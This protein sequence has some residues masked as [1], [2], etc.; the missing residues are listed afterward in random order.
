[1]LALYALVAA[2]LTMSATVVDAQ[3]PKAQCLQID[4]SWKY[5]KGLSGFYV[6]QQPP[7]TAQNAAIFF[8]PRTDLV[9]PKNTPKDIFEANFG[10]FLQGNAALGGGRET[11][12]SF[13]KRNYGCPLYTHFHRQYLISMYCMDVVTAAA[14]NCGNQNLKPLCQST[15]NKYADST[16][17]SFRNGTQCPPA[18]D[19]AA[20]GI[21]ASAMNNRTT[22]TTSI[23]TFCNSAPFN[24]GS[25]N[26]LSG[27]VIEPQ[28]CGFVSI[29][30]MCDGKSCS[31]ASDMCTKL[32][33]PFPAGLSAA[34]PSTTA[35]GPIATG[36]ASTGDA[37]TASPAPVVPIVLGATLG[38][39]F[40][41]VAAVYLWRWRVDR[42]RRERYMAGFN[43]RDNGASQAGA[44]KPGSAWGPGEDA[45]PVPPMPGYASPPPMQQQQF[46][47][48]GGGEMDP[49]GKFGA[50]WMVDNPQQQQQQQFPGSPTT[51]Q[52]GAT[53]PMMQQ[54]QQQY[55]GYPTSPTA[56]VSTAPQLPPMGPTPTTKANK[57][58]SSLIVDR[59]VS[60]T[61]LLRASLALD[62]DAAALAVAGK[63]LPAVPP[64]PAGANGGGG[65]PPPVV[66][67]VQPVQHR[68]VRTYQPTMEDEMELVPGDLVSVSQSYDDG[69]GFGINLATG[70]VGVL[71]M[72]FVVR[73]E[74]DVDVRAVPIRQSMYGNADKLREVRDQEAARAAQA[75]QRA[76]A[77]QKQQQG[78]TSPQ[79]QTVDT[80]R[81]S[82]SGAMMTA[83]ETMF[84]GDDEDDDGSVAHGSGAP[85]PALSARGGDK[86]EKVTI[87]TLMDVLARI[88][89][90]DRESKIVAHLNVDFAALESKD[91]ATRASIAS[92][93][94]RERSMAYSD[95]ASE[96]SFDSKR[97]S[98]SALMDVLQGAAGDDDEDDVDPDTLANT[99]LN[100]YNIGVAVTPAGTGA[101]AARASPPTAASTPTPPAAAASPYGVLSYPGS[102]TVGNGSPSKAPSS[103]LGSQ[104]GGSQVGSQVGYEYDPR[105]VSTLSDLDRLESML[106]QE[107]E[108][109][110]KLR[111]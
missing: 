86:K 94:E 68:A 9:A 53:S 59:N 108:M 54:Q 46:G 5:C 70:Q 21:P 52:Y 67:Y 62:E 50:Y 8:S 99:L 43:D 32:G 42:Q 105:P 109:L 71:P 29:D 26:C 36:G 25:D 14:T 101:P 66:E 90:A 38:V 81:V 15:C 44:E 23:P 34:G 111:S 2:L 17:Q 37:T 77:Q 72:S 57:R 74:Q 16:I 80:S 79:V 1:M 63:G 35:T 91:P 10:Q 92:Q 69:W 89:R 56:A 96:A 83:R 4:S 88:A 58:I 106:N 7:A 102:L 19:P 98:F 82:V 103:Q 75:Q 24:G 11:Y 31:T 64:L 87:D 100:S 6:D 104:L 33:S 55:G 51:Q 22:G 41:A 45:P 27:D 107:E 78:P 49:N 93:I 47:N 28:T 13:F 73:A 12:M 20:A 85:S 39:V 48:G 110:R 65:P 97:F 84:M 76:A 61:D 3:A 18:G 60:L 95:A 40:L 30:H